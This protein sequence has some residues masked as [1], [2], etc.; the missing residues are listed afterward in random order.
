[1]AKKD[2][3]KQIALKLAPSVIINGTPLCIGAAKTLKIAVTTFLSD[4]KD[5]GVCDVSVENADTC[6]AKM[7]IKQ[8]KFILKLLK[9]KP[10]RG[11]CD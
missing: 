2:R 8:C 3:C 4:I 11:S 7:Y 6:I 1:M 10:P 9:T 5:S